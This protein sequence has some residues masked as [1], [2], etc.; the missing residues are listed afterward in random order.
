M[1]ATTSDSSCA[2]DTLESNTFYND[3]GSEIA[4]DTNNAVPPPT[5]TYNIF[6]AVSG[7]ATD[8]GSLGTDCVS[9][10]GG[11]RQAEVGANDDSNDYYGDGTS[12]GSN[13]V[14]DDPRSSSLPTCKPKT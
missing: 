9:G 10:S 3:T 12:Y 14:N 2:P 11:G 8:D 7:A 5:M 6:D 1:I 13:A 4:G